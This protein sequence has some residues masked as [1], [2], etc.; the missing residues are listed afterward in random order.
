MAVSQRVR[1][2]DYRAMLRLAG[3]VGELPPGDVDARRRHL[4][5]GLAALVGAQQGAC[6]LLGGRVGPDGLT[7]AP[8]ILFGGGTDAQAAGMRRYLLRPEPYDVAIDGVMQVPGAMVTVHRRR[9]LD[10]RAWYRSAHYEQV[11]RPIGLDDQLYSRLPLPDG[12]PLAVSMIRA[13]GDRPFTE[14]ECRLL[15]AFHAQAGRLYGVDRPPAVAEPA[16]LPPGLPPRL[17]PVLD[18][19]VTGA[20]E[21]EVANAL[22]LSKHTVHE[23]AKMLYKRFGVSSRAALLAKVMGG[24]AGVR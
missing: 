13:A 5:A 24:A 20:S 4:L 16:A 17:K 3:E 19:F 7:E 12:R 8:H 18:R 15:D 10:D 22:G 23:Y 9:V 11:R 14:R 21:R 2:S 6:F 1:E